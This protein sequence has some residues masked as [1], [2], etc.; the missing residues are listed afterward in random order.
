MLIVCCSCRYHRP[1]NHPVCSSLI[2]FIGQ[3]HLEDPKHIGRFEKEGTYVYLWL[4]H[5]VVWQK[6]TQHCKAIILQ[7]KINLKKHIGDDRLNSGE[8]N[9]T[10]LQYSCL[11]NPM[12]GGAWQLQSM[13]SIRVRHD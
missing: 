11:E 6:P 7:L 3:L 9:G 1:L 5:V 4:I 8:G 13:G 2:V 10:P 12:D